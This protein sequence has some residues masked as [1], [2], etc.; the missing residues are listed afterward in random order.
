[1][2]YSSSFEIPS[3]EETVFQ[4]YYG[5]GIASRPHQALARALFTS[6]VSKT[7]DAL[8]ALG[9]LAS[10][11]MDAELFDGITIGHNENVETVIRALVNAS[12]D[13]ERARIRAWALGNGTQKLSDITDNN[14]VLAA[15]IQQMPP[16]FLLQRHLLLLING[17]TDQLHLN[18]IPHWLGC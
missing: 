11:H 16:P 12:S 4:G 10:P 5:Q 2:C 1:V 7:H 14:K 8:L 17:K 15:T 3:L 9:V 13:D 6:D 18:W